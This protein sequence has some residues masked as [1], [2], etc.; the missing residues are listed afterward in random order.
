[1][2]TERERL[3]NQEKN[4][5][6]SPEQKEKRNIAQRE[7]YRKMRVAVEVLESLLK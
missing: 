5:R 3:R 1:M 7:N 2:D 4:R 6:R